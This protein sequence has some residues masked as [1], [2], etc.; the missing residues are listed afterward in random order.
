MTK[1]LEKII[2]YAVKIAQPEEVILFG[3]VAE[4]KNNVHSDVDLLIVTDDTYLKSYFEKQIKG[5]ARELS[6]AVD[7]LIHS[8]NELENASLNSFTFLGNIMKYGKIIYK[9]TV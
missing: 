9:K 8:R 2:N 5:F 1:T 7:V 4:G 6:L 3:S